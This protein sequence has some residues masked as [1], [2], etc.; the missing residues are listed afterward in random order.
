MRS[1]RPQNQLLKR[2]QQPCLP[3]SHTVLDPDTREKAGEEPSLSTCEAAVLSDSDIQKS[4]GNSSLDQINDH[5]L[6][7]EGHLPGGLAV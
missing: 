3:S 1:P 5:G 4:D 7:E 6:G 2:C